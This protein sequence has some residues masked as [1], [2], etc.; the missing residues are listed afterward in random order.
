MIEC[1][2]IQARQESSGSL[3]RIVIQ[4]TAALLF[5]TSARY[6]PTG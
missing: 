4:E 6:T 1:L 5:R 2:L 3:I